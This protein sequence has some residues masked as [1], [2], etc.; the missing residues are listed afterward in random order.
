MT[1]KISQQHQKLV[2]QIPSHAVLVCPFTAWTNKCLP[3]QQLLAYLKQE[4]GPYYIV[5]GNESEKAKAQKLASLLPSSQ[6][7]PK[8]SLPVLQR[9]MAR[10]RKVIAMDSLALHLCGTTTTP[11]LS[12]F[13]P[14]SSSK[15]APR[16]AQHQ[17]LQGECPYGMKFEKR[18]T[19]L[20]TCQSGACIK[21]W[22]SK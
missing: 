18:C 16:G 11:S 22:K 19:K 14:S 17:V 15:Y 10:C 7:L 1:L 13:G 5:W 9:V 3:E 4:Q 12:F 6:L 21:A 2:E 8:V 20:R